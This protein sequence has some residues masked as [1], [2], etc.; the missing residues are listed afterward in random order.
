[1]ETENEI[2]AAAIGC[3]QMFAE[4]LIETYSSHISAYRMD[5]ISTVDLSELFVPSP[6]TISD[7]DISNGLTNP[8]ASPYTIWFELGLVFKFGSDLL[9]TK[10]LFW[11][12]EEF[13]QVATKLRDSGANIKTKPMSKQV[14]ARLEAQAKKLVSKYNRL[15]NI[16]QEN[17]RI[18]ESD[19]L[20]EQIRSRRK[21]ILGLRLWQ[22]PFVRRDVGFDGT[23]RTVRGSN[24]ITDRLIN[25]DGSVIDEQVPI[26][27]KV[28]K[29][30]RPDTKEA[31]GVVY[32]CDTKADLLMMLKA[33]IDSAGFDQLNS[34]EDSNYMI[35]GYIPTIRTDDDN[36]FTLDLLIRHADP[37][38]V[39]NP[40]KYLDGII[41]SGS[42]KILHW[43]RTK[44]FNNRLVQNKLKLSRN[45]NI[46][47]EAN[48]WLA[49]IIGPYYMYYSQLVKRKISQL[50]ELGYSIPTFGFQQIQCYRP[51]CAHVFCTEKYRAGTSSSSTRKTDCP[52]CKIAE[53]CLECRSSSHFGPCDLVHMAND[54]MILETTKP[55][56]RC[57][58]RVEKNG[59]CQHMHC[60]CGTHFC[61]TCMRIYSLN[62][63]TEHYTGNDVFDGRCRS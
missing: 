29:S 44:P 27:L 1:M 9:A 43:L 34:K 5:N 36:L 30:I 11:C 24:L 63:V 3:N 33:S 49:L 17:V 38:D 53:I 19:G 55:C 8:Y 20:T 14:R 4:K 46:D 23:C 47:E 41:N 58:S 60:I 57:S 10:R 16:I 2:F 48:I 13:A 54:Q 25:Y 56:P 15:A 40:H 45:A 51:S 35:G 61:W 22:R 50:I 6:I 7:S 42:S 52:K 37:S 59:G 39:S 32:G 21:I 62:D 31:H 28:S 26:V 12:F 18:D